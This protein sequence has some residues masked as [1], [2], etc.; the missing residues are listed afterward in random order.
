[1]AEVRRLEDVRYQQ[2]VDL[3]LSKG[4][5]LTAMCKESHVAE[6]AGLQEQLTAIVSN[7]RN[8]GA[9]AELLAKLL[10]M[11]AEV[12]VRPGSHWCTAAIWNFTSYNIRGCASPPTP[13]PPGGRGC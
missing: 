12:Q 11:L 13:H 2:M 1:M 8:P 6:P 10:H 3:V 5:E 4:A 7:D 9:A